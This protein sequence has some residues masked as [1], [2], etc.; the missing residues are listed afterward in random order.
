MKKK[1]VFIESCT[2]S[3]YHFNLDPINIHPG[4]QC[5]QVASVG[6]MHIGGLNESHEI[7]YPDS[8]TC[9][10]KILE[11]L[12]DKYVN[13]D[14][15]RFQAIEYAWNKVNEEFSFKKVRSQIEELY[16]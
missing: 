10:E 6:S 12:M 5:I 7:L 14:T 15:K 9:D 11:D 2:P 3:L 16:G 13:D 4:G 8:A 1:T